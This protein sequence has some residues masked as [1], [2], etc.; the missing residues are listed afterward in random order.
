MDS[1]VFKT[2]FREWLWHYAQAEVLGTL[3]ALIFAIL[4]FKHTHSY[5]A[6]AGAGFLGEGIGF[7]GYFLVDEIIRHGLRYK[8]KPIYKRLSLIIS[9]SSTNLFIEFAPAEIFDDIFIRPFAM[10]IVPQHIKPYALGFIVGKLGADL[11][12][13]I[14]AIAGYELKKQLH[15]NKY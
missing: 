12:F 3:I 14:F 11:V 10:F 13:Y 4:I 15:K 9:K 2:K 1:N 8:N 6:A 7:Y 5:A